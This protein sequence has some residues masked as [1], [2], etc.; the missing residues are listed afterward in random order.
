MG[1][2]VFENDGCTF[3]FDVWRGVDLTGCC[4]VHDQAYA[5]GHTFT[6]WISAN[7][8]LMTCGIQHGVWDWA[9]L[10]FIGVCSPVGAWLFFRGRKAQR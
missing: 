4:A 7:I 3:W 6:D 2:E 9:A 8:G 1:S 10:A 5:N